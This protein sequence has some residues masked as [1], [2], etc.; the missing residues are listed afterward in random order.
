MT[1]RN[2]SPY[3]LI[4]KLKQLTHSKR[5]YTSLWL[6]SKWWMWL[7]PG[8]KPL[9]ECMHLCFQTKTTGAYFVRV[10]KTGAWFHRWPLVAVTYSVPSVSSWCDSYAGRKNLHFYNKALMTCF[11]VPVS[12]FLRNICENSW[13]TL[14]L[15]G[16]LPAVCLPNFLQPKCL[17]YFSEII[18][19]ERQCNIFWGSVCLRQSL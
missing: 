3:I 4:K 11:V 15:C 13:E 14:G 5:K 9:K 2:L 10:Y 8:F 6:H 16:A 7:P 12:A 1:V 17:D 18:I 19:C